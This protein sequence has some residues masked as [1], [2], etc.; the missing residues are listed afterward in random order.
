MAAATAKKKRPAKKAKP[1]ILFSLALP[2]SLFAI[3]L[4]KRF[5]CVSLL[6]SVILISLPPPSFRFCAWNCIYTLQKKCFNGCKFE[7]PGYDSRIASFTKRFTK[8]YGYS[9]KQFAAFA[10]PRVGQVGWLSLTPSAWAYWFHK[11]VIYS[12]LEPHSRI[13]LELRSL[14]QWSKVKNW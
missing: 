12:V 4:L 13:S 7:L 14:T 3:L 1:G 5:Y 10:L 11:C 8:C 2:Q 6:F 9:S